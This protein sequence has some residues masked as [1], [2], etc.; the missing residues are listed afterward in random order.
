[1]LSHCG[2]RM[3]WFK[4]PVCVCVC[5]CVCMC[6]CV[7]V[8][9]CVLFFQYEG[10]VEELLRELKESRKRLHQQDLSAKHA[11]QQIQRE[12]A[13]RLE[14]VRGAVVA[15]EMRGCCRLYCR[16]GVDVTTKG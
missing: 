13:Y 7:C 11:I 6:V 12:A 8:C 4:M 1:M 16:C 2:S 15:M 9:V 14:Q 10:R 3:P 5:V